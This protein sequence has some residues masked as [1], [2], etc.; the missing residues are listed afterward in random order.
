MLRHPIE[1]RKNAA[2]RE[3]SSTWWER[4]AAPRLW[5]IVSGVAHQRILECVQA[6]YNTKRTQTEVLAKDGEEAVEES[7]G[8]AELRQ[9][10][11][12]NLSDDQ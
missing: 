12:N 6:L 1:K 3:N 9:Q 7:R 2:T 5:V 10:K 11:Y 4:I 8:P